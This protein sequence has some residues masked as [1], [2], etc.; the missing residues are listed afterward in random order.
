M[1]TASTLAINPATYK[2]LPFDVLSDLSPIGNIATV[3]NIMSV[4]PTVKAGSKGE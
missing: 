4:N 3:P 2:T 1:G